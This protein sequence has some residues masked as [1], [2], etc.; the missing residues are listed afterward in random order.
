[1]RLQRRTVIVDPVQHHGRHREHHA[2][3]RE[4]ALGEDV[5]EKKNRSKTNLK[6]R[7][8]LQDCNQGRKSP[9]K[10]APRLADVRS[11]GHFILARRPI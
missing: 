4:F 1:M 10:V 6:R 8:S 5:V 7:K 9:K 11:Y 2:R 3:R